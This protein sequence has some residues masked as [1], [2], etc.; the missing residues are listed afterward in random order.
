MIGGPSSIWEQ[1]QAVIDKTG[2]DE[3]IVTSPIFDH[4]ARRQ[5]YEILAGVGGGLEFGQPNS[6]AVKQ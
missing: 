1:L 5:S 4:A 3:L 6:R 2:A